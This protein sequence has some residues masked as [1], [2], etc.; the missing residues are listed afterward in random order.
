VRRRAEKQNLAAW[1][2]RHTSMGISDL[3][4]RRIPIGCGESLRVLNGAVCGVVYGV[5][6][7]I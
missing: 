3:G 4:L 7:G 2:E 5:A 6:E 1:E